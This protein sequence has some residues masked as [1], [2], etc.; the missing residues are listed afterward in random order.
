MCI[1]SCYLIDDLGIPLK[2]MLAHP[3]K[4]L[5]DILDRFENIAFTCE[6]KYDGERAQIHKL[7]D[8]G[9]KIYSRNSENM[10]N[11]YPDV[12]ERLGKV[13]RISLCSNRTLSS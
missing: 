13:C 7:E 4:A 2:P 12:M 3:T 8:G 1:D 5:T 10:S 9:M 11:K 6:Y